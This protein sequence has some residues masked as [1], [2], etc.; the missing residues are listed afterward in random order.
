MAER[1][2]L[3]QRHMLAG[4]I[5]GALQL[6]QR[7]AN[8]GKKKNSTK[9][10]GAGQCVCTAVKDLCHGSSSSRA[11]TVALQRNAQ[12]RAPGN[13]SARLLNCQRKLMIINKSG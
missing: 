10:A 5:R 6:H 1:Y 9:D 3:F 11:E 13:A 8:R 7:R 4:N 12:S 2:R